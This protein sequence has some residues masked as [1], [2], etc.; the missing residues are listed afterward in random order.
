MKSH[1][2]VFKKTRGE[3]ASLVKM[4]QKYR[5]LIMDTEVRCI[6]AGDIKSS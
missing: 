5:A 4:K 6:V 2:G 3:I 1:I